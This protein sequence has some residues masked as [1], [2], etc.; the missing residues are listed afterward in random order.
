[1]QRQAFLEGT[2]LAWSASGFTRHFMSYAKAEQRLTLDLTLRFI[3][4]F[5]RVDDA[6]T[7]VP[8][9]ICTVLK[10]SAG[11]ETLRVSGRDEESLDSWGLCSSVSSQWACVSY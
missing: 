3:K 5:S 2:L 9:L 6:H 4:V 10:F 1:M 7:S 8:P 11:R